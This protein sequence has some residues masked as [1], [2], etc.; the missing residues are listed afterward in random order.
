MSLRPLVG[1]AL[2]V[3]ASAV[4]A[5]PTQA[6]GRS[7][8][9]GVYKVD[10]HIDVAGE[11]GEY[12][13]ACRAGDVL[14][15]GM[16]RIDEVEQDAEFVPDPPPGFPATGN[17]SFTQLESV[18]P[19]RAEAVGLDA[20]A[21]EFLAV[22]GGDISGKLFATC[23][24]DPTPAVDGHAHHFTV[25]PLVTD[26]PAPATPPQ[27]R[28]A[29]SSCGAGEIQ[30]QPGFA[31]AGASAGDVSRRWPATPS[32]VAAWDWRFVTDAAGGTV[33]VSHRCLA[34]TTQPAGG[35]QHRLSRNV[36]SGAASFG[37]GV[38]TREAACGALYKAVLGA[39]DFRVSGGHDELWFLGMDP[40]PKVRAYKLLNAAAGARTAD[41]GAVCLK[42]RT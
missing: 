8:Y 28:T 42:E 19:V 13:I 21:V 30:I 35:H 40:R 3:L 15:D 14:L 31:W 39:W 7:H 41:L 32:S 22:G 1:L 16:W 36:R 34:T 4:A 37:R 26:A 29:S 12:R 9:L 6:G 25:G 23:L 38:S 18:L 20:F 10:R 24:P 33:A 27:T 17:P 5:A 2:A 11:G